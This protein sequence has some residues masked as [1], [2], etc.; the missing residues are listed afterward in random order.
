MSFILDHREK[1]VRA[2][3]PADRDEEI[4]LWHDIKGVKFGN[5]VQMESPADPNYELA[6]YQ[7]PEDSSYLV[8]V[9]VECYTVTF[10]A[11]APDFNQFGPPPAPAIAFW[12][13]T[14]IPVA[15]GAEYRLSPRLPIHIL[16]DSEEML[17]ASGGNRVSLIAE[18]PANPDA[19]ARFVRTLV[20]GFLISSLVADKIGAAELTYFGNTI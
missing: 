6:S 2:C 7:I 20:Y 4:R 17:F 5:V 9:R 14:D 1:L 18:L 10:V 15:S 11:A 12:Q 3:Q 19:N 13:Y 16:C 8:I